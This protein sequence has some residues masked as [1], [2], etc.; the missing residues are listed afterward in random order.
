MPRKRTISDDRLLDAA[1]EIAHRRGPEALSFGALAAATGLAASTLVQRFGTR[2]EMLRATLQRAW[3]Q[4]DRHTADA[5]AGAGDGPAG[6][7]ALLVGLTG[8]YPADD[9]GDYA[10]QLLLLRED[11]RDPV[12]RAR[13]AAWIDTLVAAVE[14]RL[15]GAA[16]GPL[17]VAH[18]QGLLTVWAFTR[19]APLAGFVADGLGDLLTLLQRGVTSGV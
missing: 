6:V 17:V 18:W 12:L 13:G 10:D 7:V 19:P 14:R 4:L 1:L 11:L 5:D 2:P 8:S 9:A 16:V 15:G 3:D